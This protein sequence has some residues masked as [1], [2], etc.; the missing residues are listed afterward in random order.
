[1]DTG[2][3]ETISPSS[4]LAADHEHAILSRTTTSTTKHHHQ[5][6]HQAPPPCTARLQA[7]Q[8]ER[9]FNLNQF[10]EETHTTNEPTVLY[11]AYGSNLSIEKFRG[12]RGIEPLSQIN[13]IVPSLRLTFDL[14][15]IPYLEPCFANS[16]KRDPENGS[17]REE[18][19]GLTRKRGYRKD[20]WH[21]GMVGV[22]YEVTAKDYAH[23]IATEGGGS[24]YADVLVDCHPFVSSD[25]HVPVE[26]HP[27]T[28]SF[29]A[30]TL[31][32]PATLP[33][34]RPPKDG[35]RLQRPR[36]SY[37]Q[38]SARYL[39]LIT[40][41]A[42]ELGLP[43]EYQQYLL[44]IRPY[45]ITT[46]KQRAGMLLFSVMW[47]PFFLLLFALGR[48]FQ[49]KN[50]IAPPW[51]AKLTATIFKAVWTS[52]DNVFEPAFGDGERTIGDDVGVLGDGANTRVYNTDLEKMAG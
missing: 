14:P 44:S 7:S 36:S 33:G 11:L 5:H 32:A 45:R 42:A 28:P 52:Y 12:A 24:T 6:T 29:K 25:V 9:P 3:S 2:I 15:G 40:D 27:T 46:Y 37:A 1:M 50:G 47:V 35:G 20:E 31:F 51:L 22:V 38:A 23:I 16:A 49:D 4:T 34:E 30:H 41:G 10:V 26:Q 17:T 13:V 8:E 21:K 19:G 48:M 39:K 18:S 43:N